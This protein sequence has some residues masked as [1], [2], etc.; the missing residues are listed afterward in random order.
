MRQGGASV[1]YKT[2]AK[3]SCGGSVSPAVVLVLP[4]NKVPLWTTVYFFGAIGARE[5]AFEKGS[6]FGLNRRK[7]SN[8]DSN[9]Q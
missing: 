2:L 7:I 8:V 4:L 1:F 9:S 5:K 6:R 3:M